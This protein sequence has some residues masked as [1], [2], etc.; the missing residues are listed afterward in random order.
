MDTQ[1]T[2]EITAVSDA[3]CE[4]HRIAGLDTIEWDKPSGT[5]AAQAHEAML[6]RVPRNSS[7]GRMRRCI[8]SWLSSDLNTERARQGSD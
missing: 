4:T 7:Q 8:R 5:D 3:W 1:W 6:T 2:P